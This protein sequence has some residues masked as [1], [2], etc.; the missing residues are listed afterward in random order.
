MPSP[1]DNAHA[2]FSVGFFPIPFAE[3]EESSRR[4]FSHVSR[5]FKSIAFGASRDPVAGSEQSWDD[6][7]N[8]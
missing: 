2:Q 3:S 5:Q 6:M 7:K 8:S 4:L 1:T